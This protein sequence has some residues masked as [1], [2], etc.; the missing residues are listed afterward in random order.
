MTTNRIVNVDG[1]N[2]FVREA[3]DRSMP[4]IVLLHGFPSSSHMF[5]G[6]IPLLAKHFRVIA[7]DMIGFGHSDA[8]SVDT[9][10]YSFD[11]LASVTRKLLERLEVDSYVLYVHD[12]GGP[13]GFRLATA[14]PEKVRGLVVQNANA[15]MEGVSEAVA[16]LFMPLWKEQNAQT[17]GAAR[18]FLTA[19]A[20]KGQYVAGAK[21]AALLDPTAWLVDQALLDRP[22]IAE[23]QLALFVDYQ[24]NVALYD[25]WHAY[26]R[27]HQPKTLV[28]WGKNDPFF[29]VPGAEAYKRDVPSAEVVLLDGGH[30]ALEEHVEEIAAR[31]TQLFAPASARQTVAAFYEALGRGAL[32]AALGLLSADVRWNDPKGFPYGGALNGP[33][34]V[35]AQVF[36]RIFGDWAPFAIEVT[37]I[38][39]L[40]DGQW[41][42]AIGRYTGTAKASGRSME[43]PFVHIWGVRGEW[44]ARFDTHCDTKA[45]H[46]ALGA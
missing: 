38:A 5:R 44:L 46:D 2:I 14:A 32:D 21:N 20:T 9:F 42:V 24:S 3:G 30:F 43:S 37:R 10:E 27:E 16:G 8:P 15:Y 39:A 29:L 40:E 13:V 7:P 31:I 36:E 22:G 41:V 11:N 12:Y 25:T 4:A 45:I 35:R 18:G 26:L 34:E 6:L 23:A 33:G 28:L 17:L 19:E 1:H